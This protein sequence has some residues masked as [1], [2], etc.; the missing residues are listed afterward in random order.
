MK[1][2]KTYIPPQDKNKLFME[3][4][5]S[6]IV[7]ITDIPRFIYDKITRRASTVDII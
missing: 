4:K 6:E 3:K 7:S 5:L 1:K 2:L